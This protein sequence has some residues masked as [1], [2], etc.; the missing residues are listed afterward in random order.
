MITTALFDQIVK[1]LPP[2]ENELSELQ[3]QLDQARGYENVLESQAAL[4]RA[5]RRAALPLAAKIAIRDLLDSS[6]VLAALQD[7]VQVPADLSVA[8][9]VLRESLPAWVWARAFINVQ[10][11]L[12]WTQPATWH[13][14][15]TTPRYDS[16]A[17]VEFG[18]YMS[19]DHD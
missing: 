14:T 8:A 12:S 10:D 6:G 11:L 7:L 1:A 2:T 3:A 15:P 18:G 17:E 4:K 19:A 13:A 9:D 5:Q 16:G